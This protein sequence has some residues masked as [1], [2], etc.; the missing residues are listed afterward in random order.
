MEYS[1]RKLLLGGLAAPFILAPASASA[2]PSLGGLKL[3]QVPGLSSLTNGKL[4]ISTNIKDAIYGDS[5]KDNFRPARSAAALGSLPRGPNGS[6]VLAAGYYQ[7]TAQ[8]YCLH[9]GTHGPGGGDGYLYAPVKGAATE[10]V[11]AILQ[12]S[13]VHSDIAQHDIQMLLWAIVSRA[14][15]EDLN[16][17][18]KIVAARLLTQKQLA[19]LN[20]NALSVLTSPAMSRM[21]GGAPPFLRQVFQ[22]EADM[23]RLVSAPS[24]AYADMERVAVLSGAAPLGEG[25]VETPSGRWSLH[26]DGYWVRYIPSGYSKTVIQ[27]WVAAGSV[28][29][30]RTCDLATHIA[31]PGNTSRQRLAQSARIKTG[32]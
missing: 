28:A 32:G 7:M 8:S 2:L 21:M 18:L 12:N 25:S 30:G 17:Q 29:V 13:V 23:R 1:R 11:T 31:V 9:A 3:P 27:I 5:A 4:P 14:K 6:F 26:P 19:A 10:A 22:A 16:N 15:F 24:L 20:R